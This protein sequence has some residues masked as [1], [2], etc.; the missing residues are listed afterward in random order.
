MAEKHTLVMVSY[1]NSKPFEYGLTHDDYKNAF[2]IISAHPAECARIFKSGVSDIGLIPVGALK[3]LTKYRIISDY[4][5]GCDGEVR[6][7]CIMSHKPLENCNRLITDLHSRTSVLLSRVLL[8]NFWQLNIPFT[9][10]SIEDYDEGVSDA[11]LLIGDKVFEH[12]KKFPYVY[13]LG[14]IWKDWTGLPFVFAVW[15]AQQNVSR[16][17]EV[18]I[19][20]ALKTGVDHLDIIVH[21]ESSEN[22]DLYYY[23]KHNIQYHLNEKKQE[24]IKLFLEYCENLEQV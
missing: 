15:I 6:T 10:G 12:E 14:T 24:A 17:T 7:V 19:N 1:L 2:D 20:K 3:D 4:C 9:P 13:D 16:E 22:L 21:K 18:H 23:F 11:I 5:I 8:K